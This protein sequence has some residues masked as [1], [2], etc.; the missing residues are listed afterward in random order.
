MTCLLHEATMQSNQ[1][2]QKYQY[3]DK[4]DLCPQCPFF[5][6]PFFV[7]ACTSGSVVKRL[8]EKQLTCVTEPN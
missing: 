4:K 7:M 5:N 2:I 1:A 3:T 8:V 6:I